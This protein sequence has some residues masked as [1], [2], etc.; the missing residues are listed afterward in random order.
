[1]ERLPR[2]IILAVIKVKGSCKSKIVKYKTLCI[3]TK[4]DILCVCVCMCMC[5]Y[6]YIYIYKFPEMWCSTVMVG[7]MT[8]LT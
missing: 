3:Y 5:V 4:H 2:V 1:M 7:H 8:T 6:I